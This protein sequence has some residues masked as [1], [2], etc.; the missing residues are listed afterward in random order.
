MQEKGKKKYV[1]VSR[2]SSLSVRPSLM[3]SPLAHKLEDCFEKKSL[4]SR[5]IGN[6]SPSP[7]ITFI[8]HGLSTPFRSIITFQPPPTST[9][10][11][12]SHRSPLRCASP[13]FKPPTAP[14]I[15]SYSL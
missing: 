4:L 2:L 11:T 5:V 9:P 10:R 6:P 8:P 1:A 15:L 7:P 13:S 12:R 3:L 14:R